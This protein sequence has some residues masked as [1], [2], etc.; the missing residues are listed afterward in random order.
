MK[1]LFNKIIKSKKSSAIQGPNIGKDTVFS[2][3]PFFGSEPYLISIGDNCYFSLKV[4][5]LTHDGGVNVIRNM[6]DDLRDIDL[7]KPIVIGNN[8]FVGYGT[9]IMYGVKTGDNIIIG[10]NTLVNKDLESNSVYAG[11]PA[12]RICSIDEF[13]NKHADDFIHTKLMGASD[14]EFFLINYFCEKEK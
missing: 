4:S 7:I 13:K 14:K 10:A 1:R 6:Y 11:V 3:M 8:V 5:F 12:K 9:T 2:E